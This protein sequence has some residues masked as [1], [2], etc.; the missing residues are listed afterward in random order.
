MAAA[1]ATPAAADERSA[2]AEG[3]P[4][5]LNE[6]AAESAWRLGK[7]AEE[8]NRH[9]E[10]VTEAYFARQVI[11]E[12]PSDDNRDDAELGAVRYRDMRQISVLKDRV[13]RQRRRIWRG[14]RSREQ[15]QAARRQDAAIESWQTEGGGRRSV[16]AGVADAADSKAL[17]PALERVWGS[18]EQRPPSAHRFAERYRGLYTLYAARPRETAFTRLRV[19]LPQRPLWTHVSQMAQLPVPPLSQ[20]LKQLEWHAT[21]FAP[22]AAEP[23][24]AAV[25]DAFRDESVDECSGAVLQEKLDLV[26]ESGTP[27]WLEHLRRRRSLISRTP[28]P[29]T[30]GAICC[31]LAL[32]RG[33]QADLPA[34]AAKLVSGLLMLRHYIA[35]GT[36]WPRQPPGPPAAAELNQSRRGSAMSAPRSPS[37]LGS[38]RGSRLFGALSAAQLGGMAGIFGGQMDDDSSRQQM[39]DTHRFALL[40][41]SCRL[42]GATADELSVPSPDP[43]APPSHHITIG[44]GDD[45]FSLCS[46]HAEAKTS[47]GQP[48][49]LHTVRIEQALRS[50]L[51]SKG[52]RCNKGVSGTAAAA[53]TAQ[54]RDDA[55]RLR[56]LL[57]ESAPLNDAALTAIE[58]SLFHVC[59]DRHTR[60]GNAA[61]AA[62]AVLACNPDGAAPWWGKSLQVVVFADGTAVLVGDGTLLDDHTVAETAAFASEFARRDWL[63]EDTLWEWIADVEEKMGAPWRAI[64]AAELFSPDQ[65]TAS[66]ELLHAVH[67][68]PPQLPTPDQCK[69][70]LPLLDPWIRIGADIDSG[71]TV[72]FHPDLPGCP[73][74]VDE[75]P[76]GFLRQAGAWRA[77]AKAVKKTAASLSAQLPH[78]AQQWRPE[79][80]LLQL[81]ASST[82][83]ARCLPRELYQAEARVRALS[84]ASPCVIG[85]TVYGVGLQWMG[86]RRVRMKPT[87]LLECA[88]HLT[89]HRL[90][91]GAEMADETTVPHKIR[92]ARKG[93]VD[94]GVDF[95][96]VTSPTV[97]ELCRAMLGTANRHF[98]RWE[99]VRLLR[100]AAGEIVTDV[101]DS[102]RDA[103]ALAHL[104]ALAQL[105]PPRVAPR[106]SF[107]SHSKV[108]ALY[109]AG[110]TTVELPAAYAQHVATFYTGQTEWPAVLSG[111]G[112]SGMGPLQVSHCTLQDRVEFTIA[113]PTSQRAHL[114]A[115]LL[116]STL[117]QLKEML[118]G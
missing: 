115:S 86:S 73:D 77:T 19:S 118:S 96:Y 108:R 98:S 66:G 13:W 75:P 2:S 67:P 94:S 91:L 8:Y 58:R 32:A 28:L 78:V 69:R 99:T 6:S 71:A 41:G 61:A 21:P 111:G 60:P 20:V 68:L 109:S 14:A 50:V 95:V 70:L 92:V 52:G 27:C 51:H 39:G 112:G 104:A 10:L 87:G 83:K 100:E 11:P 114:F 85:A 25:I 7:R 106:S 64:T 113:A 18:V 89:A 38:K 103:S 80:S 37:R 15:I 53:A 35:E 55:A 82:P 79:P 93:F 88:L 5:I 49:P 59:I 45:I 101:L 105:A 42:P 63:R 24:L 72:V 44:T 76:K 57:R 17:T 3:L 47:D 30:D 33:E 117:L 81:D 22:A 26:S 54:S 62:A 23:E 16:H 34:R 12:W 97:R 102:Q 36:F 74:T 9:R 29:H 1:S 116:R 31:S 4:R 110:L 46:L 43:E 65:R 40:F 84:V 90:L 56:Q 107:F 48:I